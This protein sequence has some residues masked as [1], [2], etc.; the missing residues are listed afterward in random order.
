MKNVGL[1]LRCL[2]KGRGDSPTSCGTA[3]PLP[4]PP[5]NLG[6]IAHSAINKDG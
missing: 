2:N 4:L 3:L 1:V 6:V 5:P